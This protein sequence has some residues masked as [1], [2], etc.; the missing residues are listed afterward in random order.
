MLTLFKLFGKSPFAPLQIHMEKVSSCT[1]KLAEAFKAAFA[2]DLAKV[3]AIAT[4]ISLHEHEA[5]QTKN[6]IRNHLTKGLFFLMDRSDLLAILAIQDSIADQAE[7]ISLL[8]TMRPL[9]L[10]TAFQETFFLFLEKNLEAF[11]EACHIMQ[12]LDE[13]LETS[14]GGNEAEKVKQMTERVA[15]LEHEADLLQ[16]D[17]LQRLFNEGETLPH[18][19]FYLWMKILEEVGAIADHSERLADRI[20]MLLEVK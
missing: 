7:D 3:K 18:P 13:L 19:I 2:G 17:L 15:R 11:Q 4:E 5:D 12:E 14:F 20:R 9:N 6:Y 10:P 8:L 16:A 1:F